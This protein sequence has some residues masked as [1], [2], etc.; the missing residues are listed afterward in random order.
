MAV[1]SWP[2]GVGSSTGGEAAAGCEEE[3]AESSSVAYAVAARSAGERS[4]MS[5]MLMFYVRSLNCVRGS[6]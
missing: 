1:Q 6:D 4:V 3:L 2:T 5:F